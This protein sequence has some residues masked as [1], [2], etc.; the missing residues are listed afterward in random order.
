[1]NNLNYSH[2]FMLL[3][4]QNCLRFPLCYNSNRTHLL[5]FLVTCCGNT[6]GCRL[7]WPQGEGWSYWHLSRILSDCISSSPCVL[8]NGLGHGYC[9]GVHLSS[10]NILLDNLCI[11]CSCGESRKHN[12]CFKSLQQ[13]RNKFRSGITLWYVAKVRFIAYL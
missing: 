9:W 13:Y 10:H 8:C 11:L 12:L 1:M 5:L 6:S 2:V 4:T 7:C 3:N